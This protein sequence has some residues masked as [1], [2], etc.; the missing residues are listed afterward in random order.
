MMSPPPGAGREAEVARLVRIAVALAV[1]FGVALYVIW[2]GPGEHQGPGEIEAPRVPDA[3]LQSRSRAQAEARRG[4][5]A[6]PRAAEKQILFGDLHVHTTFST[7]AFFR[8]LPLVAGEGLHPPADACDFARICSQLDFWSINDHAEAITPAHWAETLE[9]IRQ[10]N[11]VAGAEGS[12]DVVAFLGW[13]WTQVGRTPEDHYGHKNVVLREVDEGAV[14][15]RPI[16]ASGGP[17]GAIMR[18]GFP[19]RLRAGL[20]LLDWSERDRYYDFWTFLD[21]IR[22]TP[23]CPQ[24][25][26]VRELPEDCAESAETPDVLY[27]KLAQWGFDSLVIPHGNTWG[28]YTPPGS[29]W[30]KQLAGA[31][32]DPER[33]TLIEVYSGH[34]NSEEYRDFRAIARDGKGEPLCPDPQPGYE[35][36]C[37]RAG[38]IIRE[39]CEEEV[40]EPE[41]DE[42]AADARLAYAR[43]GQL[44]HL[45]VPGASAEDWKGCGQCLDCFNPAF[46]YRPGGSAQYA[47]AISNFDG[48]EKP[49]RFEFGFIAS[50]DNHSARP[51]TGYKEYARR[52]M[53]EAT[54]ARDEAW[55]QRMAPAQPASP[56]ALELDPAELDPSRAGSTVNV[57]RIAE[58]ERQASF[59]MTGG[60]VAVHAAGRSRDGIW[61]ALDRREVYGTSGDRILLWFDLVNAPEGVLPMGSSAAL[62]WSPRFRVRAVGAFEQLPGCP[63]FAHDALPAERLERLCRGECYHPG[64]KRRRITRIEVVRIRPQQRPGEPVADLVDDPWQTFACAPGAAGCVVEFEDPEFAGSA[65]EAVYYV[66]AIQEPSP[67]VNAANIRCTLDASGNCVDVDP[68]YGDYR[69]PFDDACLAMNEERAWSSPIRVRPR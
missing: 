24:G 8:S 13:E 65:R 53:T 48:D 60:L 57:L 27:E 69:T 25:V 63:E 23:E 6:V 35:P 59:F 37:W 17:V 46:N 38:E 62:A 20:P 9:S 58:T 5:G 67:A 11:A 34:G 44:G 32:H 50:S 41:C 66:R 2:P 47:L 61:D 51:G 54:G 1:L 4:P 10:C 64:E 39:R 52:E 45:S 14:P 19:F 43:L 40:S 49:R 29:S 16:S 15:A 22:D 7:D 26:D 3:L 18:I 42:R 68:C 28:F 30:D 31:M 56:E 55:Q 12:P 36:C 21:E 33:Q